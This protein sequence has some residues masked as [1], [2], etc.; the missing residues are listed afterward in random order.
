MRLPIVLAVAVLISGCSSLSALKF[1]GD[2]EV[3]ELAPAKLEKFEE[4]VRVEKLWSKGV[5]KRDKLISSLH[6]ALDEGKIYAA[7]DK[8]NVVALNAENGKEIWKRNLKHE[9]RGGVGVGGGL[10]MVS[11][12]QG[13]IFALDSGSGDLRWQANVRREVLSAP[14]SNG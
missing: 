2:K 1:W 4:T 6:P 10:V 12:I 13:R 7:S 14:A 11:D 9:L 3:D 5:G 8:G